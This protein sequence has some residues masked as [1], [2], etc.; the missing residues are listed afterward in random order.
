MLERATAPLAIGTRISKRSLTT[1]E[2][3][4]INGGQ[5]IIAPDDN[6]YFPGFLLSPNQ[7]T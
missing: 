5:G 3:H 6:K 2:T 7:E 4:F 1:L